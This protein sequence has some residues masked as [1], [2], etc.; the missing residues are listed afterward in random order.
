MNDTIDLVNP[1]AFDRE[2]MWRVL[3]R[4]V[5]SV[6]TSSGRGAHLAHRINNGDKVTTNLPVQ[7]LNIDLAAIL[8]K[9]G[10]KKDSESA[11]KLGN[12]EQIAPSQQWKVIEKMKAQLFR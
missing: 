2:A 3:E 10:G 11:R 8:G 1:P 7:Q 4:R 9:Q 6:K 5:V 12:Y